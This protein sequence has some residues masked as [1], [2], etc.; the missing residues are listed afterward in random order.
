MLWL[1]TSIAVR[2]LA[3]GWAVALVNRS[4]DWR[5]GFLAVLLGVS[6]GRQILVAWNSGFTPR[7][8]PIE[9]MGALIGVLTFL[10]VFFLDQV[11]SERKVAAAALNER[12]VAL[13][14]LRD[15]YALVAENAR[16][17]IWSMRL[18]GT[19]EF[20]SPAVEKILGYTPEE[21]KRRPPGE[22]M[23][24]ASV[25]LAMRLMQRAIRDGTNEYVYEAE[26]IARGGE[27]VW[28]EVSAVVVRDAAGRATGLVGVTRDIS[29]RKDHESRSEQLQAELLHAQK[30]EAVGQLAGGIAHDFNN[31]L[32]VMLGNARLD[33]RR[34]SETHPDAR[35]LGC[36]RGRRSEV[37]RTHCAQLTRSLL[38]FSRR[39]PVTIQAIE[40]AE[41]LGRGIRPRTD[42]RAAELHRLRRRSLPIDG[43]AVRADPLRS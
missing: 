37:G 34:S 25:E 4:R 20:V 2:V 11:L 10:A 43:E 9:A 13:Q 29:E 32:A 15:Q 3:V 39:S 7:E 21:Q 5:M 31:H 38:A 8:T 30:M 36:A 24:A 23:T 12:D 22:V 17:I 42:P 19:I 41:I 40:V 1:V 35:D 26:H 18:D 33:R 14:N 27:R 16:D 6:A 28:C